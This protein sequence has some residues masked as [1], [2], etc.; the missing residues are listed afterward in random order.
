M[1]EITNHIVEF[2]GIVTLSN[3]KTPV[4]FHVI[5]SNFLTPTNGIL[6]QPYLCQVQAQIFFTHD[7]L[8]TVSNSV[9]LIP[10]TDQNS[11]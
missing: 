8:V 7:A 6:G 5:S 3:L 10:F 9:T 1:A 4:E 2:Y 11:L